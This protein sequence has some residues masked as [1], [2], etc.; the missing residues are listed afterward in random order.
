MG[1]A[2]GV[3]GQ[4]F[5]R[6]KGMEWCQETDQGAGQCANWQRGKCNQ[7]LKSRLRGLVIVR[8]A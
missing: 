1:E 8:T 2:E 3:R 5:E 6:Q 7:R 4:L